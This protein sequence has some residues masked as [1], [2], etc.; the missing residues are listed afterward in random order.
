MSSPPWLQWSPPPD[1]EEVRAG[2]L[3]LVEAVLG[4]DEVPPGETRR[5]LRE[6]LLWK[7]TE[8]AG[9]PGKYDLR[10][11]S[12]AAVE[13]R[14]AKGRSGLRHEHV[15]PR[16]Q[17][18]DEILAEPHNAASLL[19]SKGVACVV[20]THEADAL[21]ASKEQGWQRYKDA[22]VDVVDLLTGDPVD[23]SDPAYGGP[24]MTFTMSMSG[25][26]R[27]T[28]GLRHVRLV[29]GDGTVRRARLTVDADRYTLSWSQGRVWVATTPDR[30]PHEVLAELAPLLP[31]GT[32]LPLC[33][34]CPRLV[35]SGMALDMGGGYA[36]YCTLAGEIDTDH[37]VELAASGCSHHPAWPRPEPMIT[38]VSAA[39][40]GEPWS[41]RQPPQDAALAVPGGTAVL[42]PREQQPWTLRSP[43]GRRRLAPVE[44]EVLLGLIR[45]CPRAQDSTCDCRGHRLMREPTPTAELFHAADPPPSG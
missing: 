3:A 41:G 39:E 11:Y 30:Y 34:T 23:F 16:K 6:W 19:R 9:N 29:S 40:A 37:L 26:A 15:F 28:S 18:A 43:G 17:L 32:R 31:A 8:S 38:G 45:A 7:W 44:G 2:L 35:L 36:G 13:H 42:H 27:L 14:R 20:T 33:G 24:P 21:N 4:H 10:Y 25:P 12:R 1:L 22:G 5:L